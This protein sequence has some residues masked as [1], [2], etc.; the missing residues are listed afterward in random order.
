MEAEDLENRLTLKN[1]ARLF[2]IVAGDCGPAKGDKTPDFPG[3]ELPT[4]F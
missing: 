3:N 2:Y 1:M 4:K